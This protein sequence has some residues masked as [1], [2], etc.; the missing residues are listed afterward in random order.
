MRSRGRG[1]LGRD[2]G[3]AMLLIGLFMALLSVGAALLP[4]RTWGGRPCQGAYAG[5][6]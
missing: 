2:C 6:G 1:M 3:G 4:S 5:R